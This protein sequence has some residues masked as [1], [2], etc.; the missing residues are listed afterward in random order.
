MNVSL[1]QT[2][3][4]STECFLF[5]AWFAK[6]MAIPFKRPPQRLIW[7]W[8]FSCYLAIKE[9]QKAR[10]PGLAGTL[11]SLF[12]QVQGLAIFDFTDEHYPVY[13]WRALLLSNQLAPSIITHEPISAVHDHT[14]TNQRRAS[15]LT[16]QSAPSMI[17]HERISA[18]HDH[19]ST[20]QRRAL[21]LINQS[22]NNCGLSPVIMHI[23]CHKD[24]QLYYS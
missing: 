23:R 14:S 13:Q 7:I 10:T 3:V 5:H 12:I 9:R 1:L 2:A 4:R 6:R 21:L 20:N 11:S 16:N 17:S 19:S 22:A 8:S 24:C 15:S 18:V